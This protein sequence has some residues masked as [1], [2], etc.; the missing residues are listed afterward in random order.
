MTLKKKIKKVWRDWLFKYEQKYYY[1]RHIKKCDTTRSKLIRE[2]YFWEKE[3]VK[4]YTIYSTNACTARITRETC[5]AAHRIDR[6]YF[7]HRRDIRNGRPTCPLCNNPSFN[8]M[9]HKR[10]LE[11]QII[12]E[13]WRDAL[14]EMW[15]SRNKK[16]PTVWELE[17]TLSYLKD[18]LEKEKEKYAPDYWNSDFIDSLLAEIK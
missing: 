16:K 18:L 9:E 4:C 10:A 6:W 11:K 5:H 13:V 12:S 1:K 15:N 7:S 2:I 17:E 8:S 3:Y 14:E